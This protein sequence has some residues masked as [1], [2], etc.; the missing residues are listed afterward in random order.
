MQCRQVPVTPKSLQSLTSIDECL[1][2]G[3]VKWWRH[4]KANDDY[5]VTTVHPRPSNLEGRGPSRPASR[6]QS[7]R[8]QLTVS[9]LQWTEVRRRSDVALESGKC[10][11]LQYLRECG[12]ISNRSVSSCR[13]S[14]RFFSSG[15]TSPVRIEAG[16]WPE[17]K[18]TLARWQMTAEISSLQSFI[19]GVDMMSRG[20]VLL[21]KMN[22]AWDL[23][24]QVNSCR[25]DDDVVGA[26]HCTPQT[27]A[28]D[29]ERLAAIPACSDCSVST[30][31]A[32]KPFA[33][34]A[35]SVG[36]L[37]IRL[38][39]PGWRNLLVTRDRLNC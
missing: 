11:P 30:K 38:W 28:G 26:G 32:L 13:S 18:E 6:R 2:A 7:R 27:P 10:K 19:K 9:W 14:P 3:G 16:D 21:G 25:N 20:E 22:Q 15:V 1:M 17:V 37:D 39:R 36:L 8:V 33:R 24:T 35:S 4:I 31:R 5:C 34:Q 23:V 12:Q 29:A